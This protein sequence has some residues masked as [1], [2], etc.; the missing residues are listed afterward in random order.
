MSY[1]FRAVYNSII[2]GIFSNL[3][4]CKAHIYDDCRR[5]YESIKNYKIQIQKQDEPKYVECSKAEA[6]GLVIIDGSGGKTNID[7][8]TYIWTGKVADRWTGTIDRAMIFVNE[9]AAMRALQDVAIEARDRV[10]G[11]PVICYIKRSC[12]PTWVDIT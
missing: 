7:L 1:K 4:D 8:G 10:A 5:R 6:T 12:E 2:L 3:S 11:T 9:T